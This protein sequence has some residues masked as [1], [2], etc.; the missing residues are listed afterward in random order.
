[1]HEKRLESLLL[2]AASHV[3]MAALH[4]RSLIS[5][6]VQTL[7]DDGAVRLHTIRI[8][9]ISAASARALGH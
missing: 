2:H 8:F 5:I 9:S 6:V 7:C 3:V 1:M 4:P